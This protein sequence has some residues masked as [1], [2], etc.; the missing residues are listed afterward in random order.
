MI[1]TIMGA[2]ALLGLYLCNVALVYGALFGKFFGRRFW[3]TVDLCIAAAW[4][5]LIIGILMVL[6]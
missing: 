3:R 4:V 1:F 2:I 5:C 6:L